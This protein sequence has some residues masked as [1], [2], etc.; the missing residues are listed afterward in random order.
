MILINISLRN[1]S[2]EIV[3]SLYILIKIFQNNLLFL[4]LNSI[5]LQ[6]AK[7]HRKINSLISLC[8]I[9]QIKASTFIYEYS[10]DGY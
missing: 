3:L 5:S 1:Y 4:F 7:S 9:N 2:Y 6:F 10:M 8:Y